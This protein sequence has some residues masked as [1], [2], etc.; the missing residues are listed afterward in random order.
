MIARDLAIPQPFELGTFCDAIEDKR[1]RPLVLL[2]LDG[3]RDPELPCGIW[4]GLDVADLVFYEG[5]A[6]DI[7]KIHIILH[8][9]SHM[10]LGHV[11]PELDP[12][13][14][15]L[16]GIADAE[17][18]FERTLARTSRAIA[19]V[20]SPDLPIA[21]VIRA[22]AARIRASIAA[23]R[24]A[25]EAIGFS[26]ERILQLLGRTKY[27]SAQER[28]AEQLA[29]LILERASR[30]EANPKSHRAGSAAILDRLNDAFGHPVRK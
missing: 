8:E 29:T 1:G 18:Y 7:L 12:A 13:D 21:S 17:Q 20:D 19:G 10:L 26:P 2:P 14:P 28:D 24:P 30:N 25:D 3:P 23:P 22:E 5:G 6:P 9:I 27:D 15:A 16:A 4:L 11:A